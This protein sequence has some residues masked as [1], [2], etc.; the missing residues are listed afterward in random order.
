MSFEVAEDVIRYIVEAG[1]A[2]GRRQRT[3][4]ARAPCLLR[5]RFVSCAGLCRPLL[6]ALAEAGLRFAIRW[7]IAP[8]DVYFALRGVLYFDPRPSHSCPC[9]LFLGRAGF[10]V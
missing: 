8:A 6:S 9:V 4:I 3:Y 5:Q 1:A 2:L 7:R 10:D